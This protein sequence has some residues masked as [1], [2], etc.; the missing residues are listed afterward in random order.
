MLP[1]RYNN[2]SVRIAIFNNIISKWFG[3]IAIIN[4]QHKIDKHKLSFYQFIKYI[5]HC[6]QF[7]ILKSHW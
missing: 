1:N 6:I 5:K 2:N 4:I 3:L 7:T